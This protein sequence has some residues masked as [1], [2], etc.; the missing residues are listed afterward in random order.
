LDGE[1]GA[2]D[3]PID[4][5]TGEMFFAQQDLALPGVLP[6]VLNRRH[7]SGYRHG[8]LFGSG[9]ASTLE[10]RIEIDDKEIRLLL[11][12]GRILRYPIPADGERVMPT[13]G[14]RWPLTWDGDGIVTVDQGDLGQT[15]HF[16]PG[17]SGPG[18]G[19]RSLR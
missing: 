6:L 16:P 5:V 2:T 13:R 19:V 4:V 18:R 1:G 10:Q 7:G 11:E 14:P 8:R 15:L 17:G 12:D 9:W 3:D